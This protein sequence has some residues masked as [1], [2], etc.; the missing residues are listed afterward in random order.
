MPR[1]SEIFVNTHQLVILTSITALLSISACDSGSDDAGLIADAGSEEDSTG[2]GDT[3]TGETGEPEDPDS[4]QDGLTDAQEA[5]L[6]T[7]PNK[8]DTD[9]DNYWDSWELL[10]GTDPLDKASRIYQGFWP[11]SPTKNELP[12]GSWDTSTTEPLSP[13]PRAEFL[14]QHGDMVDIYDFN[15]F[16]INET[17]E[18]SY[19]IID[20]SAQWCGPCH[21]MAEWISGAD[22]AETASLQQTYPTVRDKVYSLRIWWITVIV[23][24]AG[25]GPPTLSDAESWYSI[26][27]DN[28]IPVLVDETQGVRN[29]YNGGQYPFF[30]L[31]DPNMAVEY[32]GVPGP[33]DNPF[34]A[35]WF[36]EQYL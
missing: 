26:H 4:D 32:W 14:D 6:G 20:M 34:L 31:L 3:E 8:K 5:E 19:M 15:N 25:G 12:Q 28:H 21:N 16:T 27:Q 24:D 17:G 9:A 29:I 10:E 35:L 2:D 33:G 7:D 22:T 36:V 18:P 30:F 1:A 23:E 13:F 11:Y